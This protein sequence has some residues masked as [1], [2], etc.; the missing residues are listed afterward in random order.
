MGGIHWTL[1]QKVP[2]AIFILKITVV[3]HVPVGL[4]LCNLNLSKYT[5][6]HLLNCLLWHLEVMV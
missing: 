3:F 4:A 2:D 5:Q 6:A 1:L